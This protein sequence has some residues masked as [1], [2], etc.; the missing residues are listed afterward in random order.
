[1]TYRV[2]EWVTIMTVAVLALIFAD[3]GYAQK[4]LG[5]PRSGDIYREYTRTMP[6]YAEWRVTDPNTPTPAA[7]ANLPN[8]V[9]DIEISD[10]ANATKA[11]MVIDLWSGHAGT[12]GKKIRFNGNGWISIPEL[13]TTSTSGECYL[14]QA[15]ITLPIPLSNLQT[16]TNYFEGTCTGQTCWSFDW[17]QWGMDAI[18]VRVYYDSTKAHPTGTITSVAHRGSL[19]ENPTITATAS[20]SAGINKV[21]FIAHYDGYDTDGDGVYADW[22]YNYHRTKSESSM[23]RKNH[24][25]TATS[26]PYSVAWNTS[27]VPDLAVGGIALAACIRDNNGIWY[28]TPEVNYVSLVR[29]GKSV[30]LYKP[31][32]VPERFALRI[33]HTPAYCYFNIPNGTNL[34]DATSA[35]VWLKT[36]NGNDGGAADSEYHYI[37]I[38]G[39]S[40]SNAAYGV[41]HYYSMDLVP[42]ATS[43]LII[44]ENTVEAHSTS[45]ST[46]FDI[47][48]PGPG[49]IVTYS[50]SAYGSP[51]PLQ[52]FLVAPFNYDTSQPTNVTMRWNA[53]LSATSYRLQVSTDSLFESVA[54][55][56]YDDSTITD[57]S[58]TVTG[59]SPFTKYFWR[60]RAKNA[61]ARGLFCNAWRFTT[62]VLMPT[63][64]SPDNGTTGMPTNATLLWNRVAGATNYYLQLGIDETFAGGLIV[65]DATLTDTTYAVSGLSYSTQY[66]WHVA[67]KSSGVFSPF[68]T[69]WNFRT[70]TPVPGQVL[71]TGPANDSF[72][73]SDTAVFTWRR[74]NGAT[75]YW[76]ELGFDSLFAFK[77]F[78]STVTDTQKVFKVTVNN[79]TYFWKVRAGNAGGWGT[80]SPTRRINFAWTGVNEE[81][82]LPTAVQL[83]NNF[84]NPF[85]P[86][87]TIE[88]ALP[89]ESRV[90][91]EVY[92][93][94]GERVATLVNETRPAGYHT[95]VFDASGLASGIYLYRLTAGDIVK[96]NKMVLMK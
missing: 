41:D 81:R 75:K 84:P 39:T 7:Q 89:R 63:P 57:T 78:D 68:T 65:D 96:M 24:I 77:Q 60:V 34:N 46:G 92:S 88:F 38:N 5:G 71:P 56:A 17:G 43:A 82:G 48:W 36:W 49:V 52:P 44:G 21:E 32:G 11:E 62:Y 8:A 42:L 6:L 9:L 29:A 87:T 51:T 74:Q 59:L 37:H 91:L 73:S 79:H 30:R 94:L 1:M 67:S 76:I 70:L 18:M 25:G 45:S 55:V 16:G 47:D 54:S 85:N 95:V 90:M 26:A 58:K 15:N 4:L 12:T 13:Q 53:A 23:L 61:G 50:G 72:A 22:Q 19:T 2:R 27:S 80:A 3:N 33:T 64:V 35:N 66:F 93:I 83:R 20:G 14:N 28:M 10:L 86:S 31:Y 40:L 69:P